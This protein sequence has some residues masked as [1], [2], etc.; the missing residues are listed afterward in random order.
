MNVVNDEELMEIKKVHEND[1]DDDEDVDGE[2]EEEEKE[3]VTV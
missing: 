1:E 2:E 3:G